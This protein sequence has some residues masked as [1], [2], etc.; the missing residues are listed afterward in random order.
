MTSKRSQRLTGYGVPNRHQLFIVTTKKPLTDIVGAACDHEASIGRNADRLKVIP[1]VT[2]VKFDFVTAEAPPGI[3][4]PKVG[5]KP[6]GVNVYT[7]R[8]IPKTSQIAASGGQEKPTISGQRHG[9]KPATR[10]SSYQ[11]A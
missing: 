4:E 5:T 6:K 8:D 2:Y 3:I 1:C 7:C 11:F 10:H 9:L